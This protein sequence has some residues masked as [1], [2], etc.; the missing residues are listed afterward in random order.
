MACAMIFD[1]FNPFEND[2]WEDEKMDR[3]ADDW[4]DDGYPDWNDDADYKMFDDDDEDD[5]D[6]DDDW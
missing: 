5:E 3:E 1:M 2:E 6:E 4:D